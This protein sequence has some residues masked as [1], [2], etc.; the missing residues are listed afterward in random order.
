M[1]IEVDT[2]A[3]KQGLKGI[4]VPLPIPGNAASSAPSSY[5]PGRRSGAVGVDEGVA[6]HVWRS[7]MMTVGLGHDRC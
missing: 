1:W 3:S 7:S 2:H 6:D 5:H 4:W